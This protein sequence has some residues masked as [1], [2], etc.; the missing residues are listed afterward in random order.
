MLSIHLHFSSELSAP[1][2]R[3]SDCPIAFGLDIFGDRWTLLVIRDLLLEDKETF[4]A[5]A[6]SAERI[7][8]NTLADRLARLE[9]AGLVVREADMPDG[10]RIRY[11]PT[12]RAVSLVPALVELGYWGA[13]HDPL[14]GAPEAFLRAYRHDRDAVG[15]A[16]VG[17]ANERSVDLDCP[18]RT[19]DDAAG[20]SG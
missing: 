7:A 4:G 6:S 14:T 17:R 19:P 18:D 2:M 10:R 15:T 3:R 11:R 12:E 1:L 8:S 9:S 20:P 5:F 13:L 16:L